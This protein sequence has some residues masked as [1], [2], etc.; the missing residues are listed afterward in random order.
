MPKNKGYSQQANK[1][2]ANRTASVV[3]ERLAQETGT[4]R[5]DW[6]G[7]IRVALVF[8]NT[9]YIGM[10][11]LGFQTIYRLFNE[12]SDVVCERGFLPDSDG[13][14][15]MPRN[16]PDLEPITLESGRPLREFDV[17]AFSVSYELDYFHMV[18]ILRAAGIPLFARDR[19]DDDP[20]VIAGGAC[21][22][23]NPE[24]IADFLDIA[25]VGEGEVQ[26]PQFIDVLR[27]EQ[28]HGRA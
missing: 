22:I 9:Y 4:V 15:E 3:R 8:P 2:S 6:G 5:K 19:T 28:E 27:A 10:S 11:S 24:P 18:Q 26:V 20:L 7:R 1:Q 25:F 23:D 12:A 17:V 21:L 14:F 13:Q 16:R